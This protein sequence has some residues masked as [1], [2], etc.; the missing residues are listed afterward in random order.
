VGWGESKIRQPASGGEGQCAPEGSGTSSFC[1]TVLHCV[2]HV[3]AQ[4]GRRGF[5]AYK[6]THACRSLALAQGAPRIR[7][8]SSTPWHLRS[9]PVLCVCCPL[10]PSELSPSGKTGLLD[11]E[12]WLAAQPIRSGPTSSSAPC[13]SLIHSSLSSLVARC[14]QLLSS[15]FSIAQNRTPMDDSLAGGIHRKC[16]SS[17]P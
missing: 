11:Q 4:Q 6:C 8:C 3:N 9:G 5:S 7:S 16:R 14:T 13:A 12:P 10:D 2:H 17:R 1:G 15:L